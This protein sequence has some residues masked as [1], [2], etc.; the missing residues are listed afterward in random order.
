MDL[1]SN[2]NLDLQKR[3]KHVREYLHQ[4]SR[5]HDAPL[6]RELGALF[7]FKAPHFTKF[8]DGDTRHPIT[9]EAVRKAHSRLAEMI[10][11]EPNPKR[12]K[13]LEKIASDL[14]LNDLVE[15]TQIP[16]TP[17]DFD[18]ARRLLAIVVGHSLSWIS[19]HKPFLSSS[20][21]ELRMN[22]ATAL[23]QIDETGQLYQGQPVKTN[24]EVCDFIARRV[25]YAHA[26]KAA[27]HAITACARTFQSYAP[28]STIVRGHLHILAKQTEHDPAQLL[29]IAYSNEMESPER[30]SAI[31]L[32][33]SWYV[34]SR[35]AREILSMQDLRQ[36]TIVAADDYS[37]PPAG[38]HGPKVL[39]VA[40]S[41]LRNRQASWVVSFDLVQSPDAHSLEIDRV[42]VVTNRLHWARQANGILEPTRA[43]VEA[44]AELHESVVCIATVADISRLLKGVEALIRDI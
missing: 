41:A 38:Y 12:K 9:L 1:D 40:A 29:S 44:V 35:V 22:L 17:A 2:R 33:H 26:F 7:D 37:K 21:T 8:C 18:E 23:G 10:S 25:S 39:A 6:I 34:V 30:T 27:S 4:H 14:A 24:P 43:F 36:H 3:C 13:H 32:E 20:R 15:L 11:K 31:P 19:T 42:E 5:S 16:P 28:H